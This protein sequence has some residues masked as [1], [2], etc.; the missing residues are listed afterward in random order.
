YQTIT[1]SATGWKL[2]SVIPKDELFQDL[3][4]IKH[5]NIATYSVMFSILGLF[6][7]IFFTRI[8]KPIKAI[9]GFMKSYPQVGSDQRFHMVYNNEI[10]SLGANLNKMLDD[11]DALSTQIQ[12]TQKR[13][14]EVE[15]TKKQM[16][17]TAFRNQINPHFL[18]NTL[19]CIRAI[20]L[21]H[22]AQE[23]ANITASLSNMFRYSVKG[24]NFVAIEDEISH[25]KEYAKIINLRFMGRI[26]IIIE[27]DKDLLNLKALKMMLQ[28]IVE[29][30]VFHG[31]EKKIDNGI[32]KV[33]VNKT[34]NNHVE[35]VIQDNGYGIEKKKL[36][37]LLQH[38][39][40]TEDLA[41]SEKNTALG[42]GL[43]NIYRRLKL[44]Y[45]S[46]AE[47]TI[48]SEPHIGTK[49][50]ITFPENLQMIGMEEK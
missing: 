34:K 23:I 26:Q 42:I 40:H 32:V 10:D 15:I 22:E 11:I 45:S 25:V 6:L 37:E 24:N 28:P 9:I 17:I 31:L 38:L 29:N 41:Y 27:A 35:Y 7:I 5:F 46:T 8:L 43:I 50:I 21:F 44:F 48:E 20:A 36:E 47:M 14:Y 30:A 13:I 3:G 12:S 16:E 39:R 1:L 18:Y 2:I 49:V 33:Q 19:E 4:V